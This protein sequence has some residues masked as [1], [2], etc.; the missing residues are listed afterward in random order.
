MTTLTPADERQG[1]GFTYGVGTRVRASHVDDDPLREA[2]GVIA[3]FEE[4]VFD[5][6]TKLDIDVPVIR[7]DDGREWRGWECWWTKE[8]E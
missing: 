7:L 1:A 3:S 5:D 6:G 2:R 8:W 4:L